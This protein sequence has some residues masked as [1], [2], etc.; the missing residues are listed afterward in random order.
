MNKQKQFGVLFMINQQKLI[1]YSLFITTVKLGYNEQFGTDQICSLY[2]GFVI[3]GLNFVVKWS[4]GTGFFVR[5]N[6]VFVITEF[7]C[8]LNSSF[9]L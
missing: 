9:L 4:I 7:H 8:I 3:T 5:Y 6:Q 2:P 1:Y